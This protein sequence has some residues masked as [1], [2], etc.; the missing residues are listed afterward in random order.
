MLGLLVTIVMNVVSYWTPQEC[1]EDNSRCL[2]ENAEKADLLGTIGSAILAGSER[3]G[4]NDPVLISSIIAQ[5]SSFRI[6]P[7]ERTV[8]AERIIS[9]EPHPERDGVRVIK[10]K[11]GSR[12]C[13]RDSIN[14]SE[15]DGYLNFWVCSYGEYGMMQL[16]PLDRWTQ[17]GA[18][19]PGTA[20]HPSAGVLSGEE[21]RRTL[22]YVGESV[23][24]GEDDVVAITID[25]ETTNLP[26]REVEWTDSET[27]TIKLRRSIPAD[28]EGHAD[29][30]VYDGLSYDR[31]DRGAQLLNPLINIAIGC[32]EM[33][34]HREAYIADHPDD[35]EVTWFDW[36]G[37]YN[38]GRDGNERYVRN[39]AVRYKAFCDA[40]VEH[41]IDGAVEVVQFR[42]LWEGC[43]AVDEYLED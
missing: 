4:I 42:T 5:E 33:A 8:P 24:I 41:E 1:A 22:T 9:N 30:V 17:A 13:E 16:H 7:C 6:E 37:R 18:P 12:E 3:E 29:F 19:I 28:L 31:R 32:H 26:V 20:R 43:A 39:I 23:E 35:T 10:W 2:T 27:A 21:G 11:C 15:H 25:G 14:V 36:L 40:E 34:R 38:S